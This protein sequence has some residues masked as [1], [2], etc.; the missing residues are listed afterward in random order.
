MLLFFLP[1]RDVLQNGIAYN[2]NIYVHE[3]KQLKSSFL[4]RLL[5]GLFANNT[6]IWVFSEQDLH[7]ILRNTLGRRK[8]L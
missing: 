5:R 2:I 3:I 6:L 1:I 8:H 7:L 4:A